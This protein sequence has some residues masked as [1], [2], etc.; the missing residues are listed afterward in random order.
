MWLTG[1]KKVQAPSL[2]STTPPPPPVTPTDTAKV[3]DFKKAIQAEQ[4]QAIR[5]PVLLP[6]GSFNGVPN[7]AGAG[8]YSPYT[9]EPGQTAVYPSG[10]DQSPAGS[11]YYAQ[12]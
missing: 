9:T 10:A 6:E 1:G 3:Q 4:Q 7:G 11:Q 2:S 8:T 12:P 5:Q